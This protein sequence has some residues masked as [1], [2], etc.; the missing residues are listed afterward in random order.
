ML[1]VKR[2][3]APSI[4]WP[5]PASNT[6]FLTFKEKGLPQNPSHII[7]STALKKPP[8]SPTFP[9]A[10]ASD[11]SPDYKALY[12][13]AEAQHLQ[14]ESQHLQA[15]ARLQQTTF[16]K[17]LNTCHSLLSLP[18]AV[19]PLSRSTKGS[20]PPPTG[21]YCLLTLHPWLDCMA[22]QQ[23]I[24]MS[25]CRHL[26][27]IGESTPHLFT[28]HHQLK[29]FGE[30][31]II[32]VLYKIPEACKEFCLDNSIQFENHANTLNKIEDIGI[33]APDFSST[34][35]SR[36]DQFCI[37]QINGSTD[38]LVTTVKY[39]PSHKL[40]V[41]NIRVG[42]QLMDF[43]KT[44]VNIET[45]PTEKSQKLIYNAEQLTELTIAQEYHVMIQKGLK[46]SYITNGFSL[47]FLYIP[48]DDPSTLYY[49]LCEPNMDVQNDN[50]LQ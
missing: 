29:G 21:K 26:Q 10:M 9:A 35:N 22:T 28:P 49:Y 14:A 48:E 5:R 34:P 24:F 33:D 12:F 36:A 44:V 50:I 25:V 42:L 6:N 27:P 45:I 31:S 23:Q 40:T 18:L 7:T 30:M 15:E 39:K 17:F 1:P 3:H 47:I 4:D 16:G 46:Y 20:I 32:A 19:T 43:L 38:T 2:S 41:E 8:T 11:S 13:Q 37:H